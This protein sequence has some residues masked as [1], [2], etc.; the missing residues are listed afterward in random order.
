[1]NMEE[2]FDK[3]QKLARDSAQP[4]KSVPRSSLLPDMKTDSEPPQE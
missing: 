1:M 3:L 2:Y 4:K